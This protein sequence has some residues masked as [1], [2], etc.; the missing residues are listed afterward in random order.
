MKRLLIGAV[1][2]LPVMIAAQIIGGDTFMTGVVATSLG[3]LFAEILDAV[4]T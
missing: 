1:A 2:F 4:F 3:W